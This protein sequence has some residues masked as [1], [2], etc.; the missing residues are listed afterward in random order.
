MGRNDA[1]DPFDFEDDYDDFYFDGDDL[2]DD[3][4]YALFDAEEYETWDDE[5]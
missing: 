4:L 1:L 3:L 5:E 2:D